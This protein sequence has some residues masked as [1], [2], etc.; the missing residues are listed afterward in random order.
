[1]TTSHHYYALSESATKKKYASATA[2]DDGIPLFWIMSLTTLNYDSI[3]LT[4]AKF[5]LSIHWFVC[6]DAN[7]QQRTRLATTNSHLSS[8]LPSSKDCKLA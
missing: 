5:R 7:L 8:T 2:S 6:N 4:M 1:M 3:E